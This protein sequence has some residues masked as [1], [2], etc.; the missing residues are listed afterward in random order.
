MQANS[1]RTLLSE[2]RFLIERGWTQ[3]ADARSRNGTPVKP[4]ASKAAAW[5]LLGALVACVEKR[6]EVS[7]ADAVGSLAS[8]CVALAG[9]LEV[10][11]LDA[12]NDDPRR[13]QA[14]VVGALQRA[15]ES[16]SPEPPPSRFS[17]N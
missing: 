1:G 15:A 10:D 17:A 7:E 16:P 5:S 13:T 9:I 14:E 8:A 3:G 4:W 12:W 2:A 6:A 11:S